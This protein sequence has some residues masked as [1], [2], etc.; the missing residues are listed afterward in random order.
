MDQATAFE[1]A[2]KYIIFLKSNK[3]DVQGAYVFGSFAKG[4]FN[5]DSD[6]DLA[7]IMKNLSNSYTK[8]VELMKLSRKIDTRI[9]PHPIDESDF[10]HSNP[11]SNEILT[12]GIQ[13]V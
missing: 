1:I 12:K 10:N 6:I 13:V 2:K 9:E 7:V 5:E 8:Q 3:I 4:N 11:F